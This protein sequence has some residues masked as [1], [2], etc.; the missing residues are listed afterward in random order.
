MV[1]IQSMSRSAF[2]QFRAQRVGENEGRL[3]SSVEDLSDS[4]GTVFAGDIDEG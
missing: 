2:R 4:V 3:T 1:I